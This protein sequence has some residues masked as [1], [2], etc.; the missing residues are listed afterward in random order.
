MENVKSDYVI[1]AVHYQSDG[2]IDYV[3]LYER[4]GSSYSDCVLRKREKLV[5]ILKSRKVVHTGR[6]ISGL[7]STFQLDSQV[8]LDK[9]AKAMVLYNSDEIPHIDQLDHV[10]VL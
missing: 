2:W 1:E 9:S 3:R 4:R 5:Q 8:K 6:R 7:A 10:P